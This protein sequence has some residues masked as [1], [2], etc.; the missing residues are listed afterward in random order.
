MRLTRRTVL[1]S[2]VGV[3]APLIA[4]CQNIDSGPSVAVENRTDVEH[5]VRVN[6][7]EAAT[8]DM[9]FERTFTVPGDETR[10]QE[11]DPS[12]DEAT[13]VEGS[14]ELLATGASVTTSFRAGPGYG[15]RRVSAVVTSYRGITIGAAVE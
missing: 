3:I 9:L 7:V 8:A 2:A 6:I 5:E 11:F 14:A 15:L 10:S 4:G 1:G 13:N 12:L